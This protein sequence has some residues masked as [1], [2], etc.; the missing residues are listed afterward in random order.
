VLPSYPDGR[1]YQSGTNV[2]VEAIPAPG[3]RFIRWSGDTEGTTKSITL[4]IDRRMAIQ[5]NFTRIVPNWLIAIIATAI[6]VPLLL[7]WRRRRSK[8]PAQTS[9]YDNGAS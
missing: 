8:Y 2:V 6:A 4:Q 1:S 7:R 3:Y 9:P 5:A